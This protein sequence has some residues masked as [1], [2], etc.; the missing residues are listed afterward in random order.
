MGRV[1]VGGGAGVGTLLFDSMERVMST[2]AISRLIPRRRAIHHIA[3]GAATKRARLWWRTDMTPSIFGH[4]A[5]PVRA[6]SITKSTKKNATK[7]AAQH[8]PLSFRGSCSDSVSWIAS[9]SF[10]SQRDSRTKP[11]P[12][13]KRR[14][15]PQAQRRGSPVSEHHRCERNPGFSPPPVVEP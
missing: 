13:A 11:S 8:E 5:W 7:W 14:G 1:R 4:S 10:V 12:Q 9:I 6:C 2:T 15:P 3:T